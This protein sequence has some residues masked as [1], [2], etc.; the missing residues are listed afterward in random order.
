[1]EM[2]TMQV[3]SAVILLLTALVAIINLIVE[4]EDRRNIKH[5]FYL[6]ITFGGV[7]VFA[8]LGVFYKTH[9]FYLLVNVCFLIALSIRLLNRKKEEL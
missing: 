1:M 6:K 3:I 8:L 5:E 2:G 9:I 7:A 4:M